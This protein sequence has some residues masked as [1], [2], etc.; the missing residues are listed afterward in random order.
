METMSASLV[1][2]STMK[3]TGRT[4]AARPRNAPPPFS[5]TTVDAWALLV[6]LELNVLRGHAR[7]RRAQKTAVNIQTMSLRRDVK[8][9]NATKTNNA[10]LKCAS[11]VHALELLTVRAAHCTSIDAKVSL[12][13]LISTAGKICIAS[14]ALVA[15]KKHVQ[16]QAQPSQASVR[17]PNA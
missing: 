12:A 14:V 3:F 6:I 8:G 17:E 7:T 13:V 15:S 10:S 4:R 2:A 16:R 9:L 5:L 1:L 11:K